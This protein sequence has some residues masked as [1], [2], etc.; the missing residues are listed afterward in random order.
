MKFHKL[1]SLA[2]DS[3][4]EYVFEYAAVPFSR[5]AGNVAEAVR[6]SSVADKRDSIPSAPSVAVRSLR[7]ASRSRA[8]Y[9]E[10][11]STA[12][13]IDMGLLKT[14]SNQ[15]FLG[16]VW[17]IASRF[18]WERS[19]TAIGNGYSHL[20][21]IFSDK[22]ESVNVDYYHG[23][24]LVN[25]NTSK[26][27]WGMTLGPY[28]NGMDMEA[29]PAKDAMFTHEYGHTKQS[30]IFG[31]AYLSA[32]GVPSIIGAGFHKK[33]GHDHHNEWYE[34]WANNLSDNYLS[35]NGYLAEAE[36]FEKSTYPSV[37]NPDWYFYSSIAY[38]AGHLS[39]FLIF[40][41]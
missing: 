19:A 17:T 40:L 23:A 38:Y 10:K 5:Y 7:S 33:L 20:R 18:T 16:K 24:T 28:I 39:T 30:K 3:V 21:N 14:D 36:S 4:D 25:K 37:Q 41:F 35:D 22:N 2:A 1:I 26:G 31:H 6:K 34:V 13:K 11:V 32:V 8:D 12:F 15:S 27:E 29:D 9:G